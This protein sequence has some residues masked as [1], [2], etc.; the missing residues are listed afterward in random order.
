MTTAAICGSA[1]SAIPSDVFGIVPLGLND[2]S[3]VAEPEF[4]EKGRNYPMKSK[5]KKFDGCPDGIKSSK[6]YFSRRNQP[7]TSL[8]IIEWE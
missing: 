8:R 6:I 1:P 5:A 3:N 7:V 4:R 2:L